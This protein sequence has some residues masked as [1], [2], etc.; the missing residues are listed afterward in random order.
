MRRRVVRSA[1]AAAA[2]LAVAAPLTGVVSASAPR[3]PKPKIVTVGDDYFAPVSLKIRKGA[4][5]RWKWSMNNFNT[6]NVVL[7]QA[8]RVVKKGKFRSSSGAI[9]ILFVRK[10]TVPGNYKFVC[11]L[12]RAVMQMSVTVKRPVKH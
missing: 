12:H 1:L 9:G 3:Q 6:H 2:L 8:P 10:F 11:T 5:V 4:R 7:T